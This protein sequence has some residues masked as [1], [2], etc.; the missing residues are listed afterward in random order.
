LCVKNTNRV[1]HGQLRLIFNCVGDK[2]LIYEK[3]VKQAATGKTLLS[4]HGKINFLSHLN[5]HPYL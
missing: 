3:L 2:S 5:L 1:T 4:H